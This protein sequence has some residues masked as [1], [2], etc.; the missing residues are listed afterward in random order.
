MPLKFQ[1]NEDNIAMKRLKRGRPLNDIQAEAFMNVMHNLEEHDD[2]QTTVSDLINNMAEL[3]SNSEVPPYSYT[4]M[5]D[6]IEKKL[7]DKVIITHV[8]GKPNVMREIFSWNLSHN[9]RLITPNKKK[10]K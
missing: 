4:Y 7:S 5:Q 3:L 10:T 9:Q 6:Q 8:N 1:Q 2:E